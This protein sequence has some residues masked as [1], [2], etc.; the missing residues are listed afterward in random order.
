MNNNVFS[1]C[2]GIVTDNEDPDNLGRVKVSFEMLGKSVETDWIPV[3]NS[4][5]SSEC[6]AFFLPEVDD[7]I[8]IGFMGDNPNHSI[9]LGGVWDDNQKPPETGENTGSDLNQDGDNNLRFIKTRSGHQLILDDKDGEEKIQIITAEAG[10]RYEFSAKDE[11]INM[12]TDIDLRLSA[13]GTLDIEADECGIKFDKGAK[14]EVDGLTIEAKSKDIEINANQNLE[15]EGT[16]V[17]LN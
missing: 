17:K 7:Q 1:Y 3:A 11:T 15:I 9:V 8:F 16:T 6:G 4:Y 2:H 12:N 10:T 13:K 5:C 14:I